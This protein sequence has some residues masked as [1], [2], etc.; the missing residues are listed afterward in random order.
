MLRVGLLCL[1]PSPLRIFCYKCGFEACLPNTL[2]V[3]VA[4]IRVGFKRF[5]PKNVCSEFAKSYVSCGCYGMWKVTHREYAAVRVGLKLF[6]FNSFPLRSHVCV[7]C[8]GFQVFLK[9]IHR[10]YIVER[11]GFKTICWNFL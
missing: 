9:V 7:F 4:V 10:E 11:M 5:L 1:L 8:V 6:S 2:R 3:T